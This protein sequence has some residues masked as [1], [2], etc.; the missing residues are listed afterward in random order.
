MDVMFGTSIRKINVPDVAYRSTTV[1]IW[2]TRYRTLLN[3][4]RCLNKKQDKN[5]M[6]QSSGASRIY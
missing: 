6:S 4:H 2:F 1:R 3:I 5:M